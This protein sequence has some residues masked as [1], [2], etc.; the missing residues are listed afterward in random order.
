M[1]EFYENLIHFF[2]EE[3]PALE[4]AIDQ[5]NSLSEKIRLQ[6]VRRMMKELLALAQ[7]YTRKGEPGD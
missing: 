1:K 5:E 3:L 7:L 2:E 4:R 6:R